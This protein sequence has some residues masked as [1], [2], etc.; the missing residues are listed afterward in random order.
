MRHLQEFQDRHAG[1]G[2][3][4]VGLNTH[5]RKD[6]VLSFLSQHGLKFPMILDMSINAQ[7]VEDKYGS[8]AIP[9]HCIFGTDGKVVDAWYGYQ[10]G[11]ARAKRALA[12]CGIPD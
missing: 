2:L 3:I 12:R 7:M 4:V 10:E 1:R 6:L 5:D 8:A 11:H 9:L